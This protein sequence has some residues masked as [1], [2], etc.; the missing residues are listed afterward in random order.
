MG[1]VKFPEEKLAQR[2]LKLHNLTIPFDLK[3]LVEQYANVI[4]MHIPFAGIDGV[5][6]NLKVPGKKPKVIVNTATGTKR[7]NFTLAHELGHIIIPWHLG[8]IIDETYPQLFKDYQYSIIEQEANRFAAELLMPSDW[9]LERFKSLDGDLS[10]LH[11]EIVL[12][13]KVS[14]QAAAIRMIQV[15]PKDIIYWA[16]DGDLIIHSGRTEKTSAFLPDN[17]SKFDIEFYPYI[18]KHFINS[19]SAIKY[20]WF[21]L[22]ANVEI[23]GKENDDR[24]WKELFD[25]IVSDI[26]PMEEQKNFKFSVNG[27]IAAANGKVKQES[28]YSYSSVLSAVLYRLRRPE[29][30]EFV[31][32]EDFETFVIKKVKS[33]LEH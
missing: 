16:V 30:K 17:D 21:K 18:E 23:H 1:L 9:I 24:T 28:D 29:L 5:S 4:F 12:V 26:K 6:L 11:N 27:I 13:S 22:S 20:Y 25:K 15:L 3:L 14:E 7:Q 19:K 8:T 33:M 32:H 10:T 31:S 2:V